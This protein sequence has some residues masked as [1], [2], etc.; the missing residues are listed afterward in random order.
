RPA[1]RW[2]GSRRSRLRPACVN[3]TPSAR[4]ARAESCRSW[5]SWA[6]AYRM[7]T[8]AG[9][10]GVDV[11]GQA[12][13]QPREVAGEAGHVEQAR[14]APRL[15]QAGAQRGPLVGVAGQADGGR[16]EGVVAV[17]VHRVQAEVVVEAAGHA[18][19]EGAAGL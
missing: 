4:T 17:D 10:A 13:R 8:A 11:V 14:V 6:A 15:R 3:R 16:D 18:R 5:R 1:A 9:S 2:R 12:S 19:G 7:P